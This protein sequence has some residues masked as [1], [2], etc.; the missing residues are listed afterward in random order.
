[1][2]ILLSLTPCAM[3]IAV[4]S[5]CGDQPS[6]GGPASTQSEPRASTVAS[7]PAAPAPLTDA[8]KMRIGRA[9]QALLAGLPEQVHGLLG[10]LLDR[11]PVAADAQFVAGSAAYDMHQYGEAVSRLSDAVRQQPSYLPNSSALG[12]AHLKLGDFDAARNAFTR[13]VET[14]PGKH[15]AHYG[16]GLVALSL[17]DLEGARSSLTEALHLSPDYLKAQFALARLLDEEGRTEEALAAVTVVTQR[18]PSHDE[19]LYLMGRLLAS[20]GR[21]QEAEE[22]FARHDAVYAIKESLGGLGA[23]LGTATD[24]PALRLQMAELHAR[25]GD[26]PEAGRTLSAALRLYPEDA[27]LQA[28]WKRLVENR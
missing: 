15:K 23:Q 21:E 10:D 6:N 12:F 7:P 13:I 14:A 25:M 3:L 26:I 24:G 9:Q 18:W 4:A 11:K 5:G 19:A 22:V 16:L 27:G 1:M 28:A 20:L 2:R 17:G 8:D